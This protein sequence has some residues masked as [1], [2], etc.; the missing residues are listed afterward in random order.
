MK[1]IHEWH[2]R[3]YTVTTDITR[4]DIGKIHDY[5]THSAWAEG[6]SRELVNES[7]LNSLCFGLFAGTEQIGFA[8]VV[9]DGVT[10][11]YLCDV[12]IIG[13]YQKQGLGRWLMEC[14]QS[15]PVMNRLRRIMLVTSSA[16]W[17]YEKSGYSP[18]NQE[19]YIWQIVRPDIYKQ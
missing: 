14:C 17:L 16:P 7:I 2:D 6:I 9:T 19:N 3:H 4:L 5:L 8:R 13:E 10:F 12:Y 18:V 1:S 15:H 11:G